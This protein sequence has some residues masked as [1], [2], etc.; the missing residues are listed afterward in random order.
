MIVPAEAEA[1]SVLAS[2]RAAEFVI[3][4]S[5]CE[6]CT[7]DCLPHVSNAGPRTGVMYPRCH[8]MPGRC[9]AASR[10]RAQPNLRQNPVPV[11]SHV[12]GRALAGNGCS[13]VR[14]AQRRSFISAAFYHERATAVERARLRRQTYRAAPP[15]AKP[16]WIMLKACLSWA[17][18]CSTSGFAAES[19]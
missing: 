13:G 3:E 10:T 1:W 2:R 4:L 14:H 12:S 15:A 8:T 9:G 17:R 19:Q 18:P 11:T 5:I 6:C 7:A 16:R